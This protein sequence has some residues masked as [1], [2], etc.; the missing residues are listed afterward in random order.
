MRRSRSAPGLGLAPV[1]AAIS[2][3]LS[4]LPR[5]K[6]KG[7]VMPMPIAAPQARSEFRTAAEA[8]LLD[9]VVGFLREREGIIEAQRPERG[10]PNQT[11]TDRAANVHPIVDRTRHRIGD[12][13][14]KGRTDTTRNDLA[15]GGGCRRP[16]GISERNRIRK[17]GGFYCR[18]P[19]E[20]IKKSV[21][22]HA[23]PPIISSAPTRS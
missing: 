14:A 1:R 16:G 9:P 8:E 12:A 7:S 17:N 3:T 23:R 10:F 15:S 2:R 20:V 4:P 18:T 5:L 19:L 11:H 22:L 21:R 6:K 13:W